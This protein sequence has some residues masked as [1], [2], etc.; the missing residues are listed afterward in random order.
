MKL[1]WLVVSLMLAG[2]VSPQTGV[3][4]AEAGSPPTEKQATDAVME[5]LRTRLKDP[6]SIKQ[7]RI[8]SGPKM[9]TWYRGLL[10]GGGHEQAW[11]VCFEYNAKNSYGAYVGLQHDA[12][13]MRVSGGDYVY[14]IPDVN[15]GITDEGCY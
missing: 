8:T 15:W 14:I 3:R 1:G 6:D 5:L 11:M 9:V 4:V 10:R 12:A 2:C 7:F 13:A